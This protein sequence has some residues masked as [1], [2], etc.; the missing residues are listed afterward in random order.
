MQSLEE[1]PRIM[2]EAFDVANSGRPGPVL[3]DI[4]KDIQLASGTL[5]PYFTTVENAVAFPH[6]EIEQARKMLAKAQKPVLYVGGG[7]GMAQAVPALREFIA[8]THVPVVCTLKGLG[9][10]DADYPYYLG[11]LG[12]HGTKA[13][14]FAVQECDLLIAVGA[15]FDD[16]V[17]GKLNT[18]APNASVIHMDIDPAE[19]NKLRQVHVALQGDLNM[20]LPALQQPLAINEWCQYAADMRAEHAGAT[21][22]RG[23][24]FTL[25]CC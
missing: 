10:V 19:M 22:I 3:V 7:V 9:A 24:L 18:F 5:E 4:P 13:A 23:R 16:R 20:L 6:A 2:A 21:I 25:R 14:N 12:M 8:A 15:R 17:T 1:L 11:M